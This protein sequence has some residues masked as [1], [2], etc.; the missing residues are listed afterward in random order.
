MSVDH[1][2]NGTEVFSIFFILIIIRMIISMMNPMILNH[3]CFQIT[4]GL[5]ENILA[6]APTPKILTWLALCG[7]RATGT[8]LRAP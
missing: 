6:S 8:L 1:L 3:G 5:L 7:T 2:D 4:R